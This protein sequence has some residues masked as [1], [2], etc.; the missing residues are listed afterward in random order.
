MGWQAQAIGEQTRNGLN[1]VSLHFLH[2]VWSKSDEVKRNVGYLS[3]S[4]HC[5]MNET[6]LLVR[7]SSTNSTTV[8]HEGT[9]VVLL[10]IA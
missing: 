10:G 6:R 9:S 2:Y 3:S 1:V 4:L 5:L 7:Y 8:I